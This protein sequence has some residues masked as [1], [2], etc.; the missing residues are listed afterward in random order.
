M[1]NTVTLGVSKNR[2]DTIRWD[3]KLFRDLA[4]T[5]AIVEVVDSRADRHPRTP[6]HR[7]AALRSGFG[8]D[9]RATSA[10][11]SRK[12]PLRV[13]ADVHRDGRL[14]LVARVPQ[15]L[16]SHKQRKEPCHNSLDKRIYICIDFESNGTAR[17]RVRLG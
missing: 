4:D 16:I 14:P 1:R 3:F 2:L 8:L 7:S 17:Q 9:E 15:H 6:Q 11:T 10:A 5:H 12:G 13:I